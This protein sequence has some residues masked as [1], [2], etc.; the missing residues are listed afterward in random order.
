[1]AIVGSVASHAPR[2]AAEFLNERVDGG[3]SIATRPQAEPVPVVHAELPVADD[4]V[5]Q[6]QKRHRRLER[7]AARHM[8]C[9]ATWGVGAFAARAQRELR[10]TGE[11]ARKRLVEIRDDLTAQE[12]EIA[13][14]ARDG[15]SNPE[16]ATRLF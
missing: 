9:S 12:D 16:I 15:L 11:T 14:L 10:G 7:S 1:M 2:Q 13:R 8:T 5:P 3:F 6:E 4:P